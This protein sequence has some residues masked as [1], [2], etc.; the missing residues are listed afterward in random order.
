VA[1]ATPT[2]AIA[3]NATRRML[4]LLNFLPTPIN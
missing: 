4:K 1:A 2:M 3:R